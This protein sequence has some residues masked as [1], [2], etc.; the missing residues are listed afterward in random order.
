MRTAVASNFPMFAAEFTKSGL[1]LIGGGGGASNTGV[2]NAL[3]GLTRDADKINAKLTARPPNCLSN[4]PNI[5]S[6][7]LLAGGIS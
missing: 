3:V 5:F 1:L 6:P 2:P 4:A 7:S